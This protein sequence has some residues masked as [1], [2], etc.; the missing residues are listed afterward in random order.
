MATKI[1]IDTEFTDFV[2]P[3]L[4]SIG[5]VAESGQEFYAEVPY[6]PWACSEFVR[7]IV[8]PMLGQDPRAYLSR[9]ELYFRM[10]DWLRLI[11]PATDILEICYDY[12]TDWDLFCLAL[13]DR[14]PAW[15]IPR[16][17]ANNINEI[18]RI[19]YHAKHALPEHHALHDARANCY[20]F[21]ELPP[22]AS[23]PQQTF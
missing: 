17:V 23:R 20:A 10:N 11:K 15:C 4:I 5:L 2:D 19:D 18:L 16:L 21:R 1:F 13:E 8:I 7:D 14:P 6:S 12:Q 3:Q 22:G 9:D